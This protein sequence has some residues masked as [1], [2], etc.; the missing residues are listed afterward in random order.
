MILQDNFS[1]IRAQSML[2]SQMFK[3]RLNG[4][5]HDRMYGYGQQKRDEHQA[6]NTVPDS[7]VDRINILQFR[8]EVSTGLTLRDKLYF[9]ALSVRVFKL[10]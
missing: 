7:S 8:K 9:H 5:S 6:I 2:N 10:N 4:L 1:F 3:H